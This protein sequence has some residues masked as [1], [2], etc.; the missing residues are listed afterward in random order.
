MVKLQDYI[1]KIMESLSIGFQH[2]EM[3]TEN[4]PFIVKIM[5]KTNTDIRSEKPE[6]YQTMLTIECYLCTIKNECFV[7]DDLTFWE[8]ER[9]CTKMKVEVFLELIHNEFYCV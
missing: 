2:G 6:N 9:F 4:S 5:R 3:L 7:V 8:G 1:K